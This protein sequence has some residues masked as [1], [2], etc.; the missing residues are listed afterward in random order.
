M[1]L[2]DEVGL[3]T[4]LVDPGP[5]L[6]LRLVVIVASSPEVA[7]PVL[8]FDLILVELE[9]VLA[10]LIVAAG[11]GVSL[12]PTRGLGLGLN[13]PIPSLVLTSSWWSWKSSWPCL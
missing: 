5:G 7:D 3:G 9:V 2:L 13:L 6:V 8:G 4:V 12:D 1:V 11:P 10:M